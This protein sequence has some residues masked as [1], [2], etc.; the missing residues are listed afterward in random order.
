M[1]VGHKRNVFFLESRKIVRRYMWENSYASVVRRADTTN[2]DSN[3][4]TLVEKF[5]QLEV[6]NWPKIHRQLKNYTWPNF[7]KQQLINQL[8]IGRDT[9]L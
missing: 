2:Q 8:G 1:E 6:N 7:I 9:M 5:I 4:R 3:Y